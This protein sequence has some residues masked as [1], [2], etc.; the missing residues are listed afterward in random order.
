[1]SI[2]NIDNEVDGLGLGDVSAAEEARGVSLLR[3]A[4]QRRD[5]SS[6]VLYLDVPSWNGDMQAGY[7]V[8]DRSKLEALIRK[9]QQLARQGTNASNQRIRA[10][11]DVILEANMGL[12]AYDASIAGDDE[13]LRR[14][15]IEDEFGLVTWDRF[16]EILK[17][18]RPTTP[19]L[20]GS[21]QV[22]LEAFKHPKADSYNGVAVSAHAMTIAR[23][24]RDPS[25][26][27]ME[28]LG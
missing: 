2:E 4:S 3:Q 19:D 20:K 7:R 28:D 17:R 27:P 24:M 14:V 8:V 26:D 25:K 11:I 1:V 16:G 23:W 10:D 9:S 5:A 15:P 22:V 21:W 13:D 12:Y 18:I 6:G